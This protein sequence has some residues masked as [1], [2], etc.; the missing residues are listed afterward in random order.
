MSF[1]IKKDRKRKIITG[2]KTIDQLHEEKMVYLKWLVDSLPK[3]RKELASLIKKNPGSCE[4]LELE[5][6]IKD[7]EDKKEEIEYHLSTSKILTRFFSLGNECDT[8]IDI[9]NMTGTKRMDEKIRLSR[10]YY[11][12][13]GI[14][15]I[16]ETKNHNPDLLE[17]RTLSYCSDC[18]TEL[19][20]TNEKIY[21]C[22]E[23]GRMFD[24][25]FD[26]VSYSDMET[27]NIVYPFVYKRINYFKELLIQIQASENVDIEEELL[28]SIKK[29]LYKRKIFDSSKITHPKLKKILKELGKAKYYDHIPLL[30]SKLCG[31]KPLIIPADV[32]DKLKEMFMTIQVPYEDLKGDRKNFFSYPYILYKLCELLG[33]NE[34]LH[35]FQ[36]L[37]NREKLRNQDRLWEKIVNRI[38]QNNGEK[39][40]RYIPTC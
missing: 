19:L 20:L 23:C 32:T 22:T 9:E 2:N 31:T 21:T 25:V 30:M 4:V 3:R 26:G 13:C 10:E 6:K 12:E 16:E 33:L 34:Y 24:K 40:W 11:K 38:I 7:I 27:S 35:Y 15:Y 28:D 1:N 18:D 37:K 36:L 29:E 14:V 5:K 17:S 8:I 39:I